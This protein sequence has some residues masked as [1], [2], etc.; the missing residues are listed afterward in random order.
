MRER[1]HQTVIPSKAWTYPAPPKKILAIRLQATGDTVITLPYLQHLRTILPASTQIDLLTR[2]ECDSIPKNILLFNRVYSIKGGRNFKKQFA[3]TWF[4]L[5]KLIVQGYDIVIDLQNNLLSNLIRR[6]LRPRAWSSFDRY[7]PLSAGERTR[8]TIEATGLGAVSMNT[9]FKLH[10]SIDADSILTR[11]GWNKKNQLIVLNPAAAFVTRNWPMENYLEFAKLWLSEFPDTQFL[12]LGTAQIKQKANYFGDHL[13]QHTINL[14]GQ[15]T[16]AEAF[17]IL[18]KARLVLSED[19]GLMHMSWVSGV[20]TLAL[21]GATRSDWA[22]PLGD[23]SSFLDSSDLECGN[24]MLETC[25]FGDVHCLSRFSPEMIF[26]TASDLL[27]K[28]ASEWWLNNA[29]T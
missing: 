7:S 19:S 12:F 17:A 3:Y 23:H 11:S 26:R 22:R 27:K 28:Q 13:S 20:P 4:V 1:T 29:V 14:V 9:R 16:S 18:Q 5:P 21:F 8:L 10:K 15:T 25:R 2:E 24:C 6:V